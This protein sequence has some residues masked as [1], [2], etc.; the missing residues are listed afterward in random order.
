MR[1]GVQSQ[2]YNVDENEGNVTLCIEIVDGCLERDVLINYATF[3]ATALSMY[4]LN[5]SVCI[6]VMFGLCTN[7]MS[8]LS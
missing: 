1:I 2:I 5:C 7:I 3:D 4:S 8:T 6:L